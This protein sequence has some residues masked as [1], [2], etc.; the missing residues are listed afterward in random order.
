MDSGENFHIILAKI[1]F[2]APHMK[3]KKTDFF[4]QMDTVNLERKKDLF[5][6]Y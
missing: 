4:S 1:L 2:L 5:Q 6:Q 3:Y